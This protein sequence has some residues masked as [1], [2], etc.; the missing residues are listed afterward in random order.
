VFSL[1]LFLWSAQAIYS[2][3]FYA[4]GT[5]WLP[6]LS[7]T[8]VTIAALPLYGLGYRWHGA[9]G[10]AV[11]SDIGIALQTLSLA[12]MLHQRRMVSLAS[13]DY[14]ELGRCFIAG[15]VSGA[16]VWAAIVGLSHLLPGHSRW[17]DALQLILGSALWVAIA[18]TL[19]DRLG[20]ALPRAALKRLGRA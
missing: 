7:S 20:S 11:A 6:M 2:R 17:M 12:V 18:G 14:R 1:S 19:L 5:T 4:S 3:A 15:A 16:A 10:L 9:A 13:I 8:V